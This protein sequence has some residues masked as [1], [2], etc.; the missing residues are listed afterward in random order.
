MKA[1]LFSATLVA[2][3]LAGAH[4]EDKPGPHGGEIRMPGA[5]HTEAVPAGDKAV[6]IYLLDMNWRNPTLKESQVEASIGKNVASCE[7]MKDHYHC[8][9]A[10]GSLKKGTL[11]VK[12]RR[13]GQTGHEAKYKLPLKFGAPDSQGQGHHGH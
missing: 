13:E 12:S 3:S 10:K 5:Y 11:I 9:F 7:P 8:V 4:G 6:M 2:G 1:I